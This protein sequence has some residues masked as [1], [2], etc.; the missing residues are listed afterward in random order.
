VT[1]LLLHNENLS[2]FNEQYFKKVLSQ[3]HISSDGSI[4][5]PKA[6]LT[7]GD[8]KEINF[9][10]WEFTKSNIR[11]LVPN[12]DDEGSEVKLKDILPLIPKQWDIVGFQNKEYRLVTKSKVV[13][14]RSENRI[15]MRKLVDTINCIPHTNP[16][17]RALLIMATLGQVFSR[18]YYRFSSPPSFGKD[19]I[20]DTMGLLIGGCATI[21]NP[22][23]PK[24]EREASIRRVTGLN[25]VVG[26]TRSQW[27]DIGKFML[28]ACAFKP[29]ITKRTR[30]FGGV[31]ET[32]NLR[33]YSMS[34]FY[35][36]VD[37][38]SDKKVV[39]FDELAEAGI[40]DRLPAFRFYGHFDYDFNEINNI[41]VEEFVKEHWEDY[42]DIIYTITYYQNNFS[43]KN[44]YSF[45]I[46]KFPQRWQRSI[47]I[48]LKV[49]S[50]YVRDQKE[51]DEYFKILI[52]SMYDYNSMVEYPKLYDALVKAKGEVFVNKLSNKLI[53]DKFSD[54]IKVLSEQLEGKKSEGVKETKGFW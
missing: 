8:E 51:F 52:D 47:G 23:V 22:S 39:Y 45:D 16:K 10:G 28:A 6:K 19:S 21:E 32:I 7:N 35:N 34:V 46:S 3:E 31:G 26:L 9:W 41:N 15:G 54:K 44:P 11:W 48:L 12:T 42:L 36:D 18:S 27:I 24:L 17:Q 38:Y 37:C 50:L 29:S 1:P 33:G 40:R 13:K 30:A 53:K 43:G 4:N 5:F 49:L 20:V 2:E 25:E 14:Y